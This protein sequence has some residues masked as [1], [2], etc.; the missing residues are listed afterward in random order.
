M[1]RLVELEEVL[2]ALGDGAPVHESSGGGGRRPRP[3]SPAPRTTAQAGP[4]IARDERRD[5]VVP[6]PSTLAERWDDIVAAARDIR[7]FLGAALEKALP[8]AVNARGEVTL[9]LET[10]DEIA[11][12][13]ISAGAADVTRVIGRYFDGIT[14]VRLTSQDRGTAEPAVAARRYTAEE[15][16]A[17]RVAILRRRDPTLAAAIDALDLELIE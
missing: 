6:L 2:R 17:E 5:T 1:D 14:R 9:A 11:G 7:P 10:P 12:Q 8:T 3:E 15:V 13:A 4:A 16:R